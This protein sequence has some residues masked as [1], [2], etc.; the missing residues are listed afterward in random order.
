MQ[1]VRARTAKWS[2]TGADVMRAPPTCNWAVL[3]KDKQVGT[4]AH[5]REIKWAAFVF[6]SQARTPDQHKMTRNLLLTRPG[7]ASGQLSHY[8]FEANADCRYLEQRLQATAVGS[9]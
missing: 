4:S 9:G 7:P 8:K 2:R 6:R 1:R 3:H 5:G